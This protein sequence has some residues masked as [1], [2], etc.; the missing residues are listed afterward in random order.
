MAVGK[1]ERSGATRFV[2]RMVRI[3]FIQGG[4][5]HDF[6]DA[7]DDKLVGSL[8]RELGEGFDVCYPR[9][10]DEDDPK[11]GKW[12]P[13][14][15]REVAK[16]D[17]GASTALDH[18]PDGPRPVLVGHSIGGT[19][20]IHALAEEPPKRQPAA[21]VL[22]SAPFVGEGG[23]PS[24]EIESTTDLGGKLPD[25]VP[26][27]LFIGSEDKTAPPSHAGLYAK[28]IP[29]AQIHR[30]PGRDHQLNNELKEVAETIR[31]TVPVAAAAS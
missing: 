25:G 31:A 15:L 8:R 4:G 16:L 24:D 6:H 18:P 29:L 14:I 3:L 2:R 21:I 22:I 10:P 13:A 12:K 19:M 23:W 30:L 17:D 20:L 11:Y 9:M 28:A 7:W 27:H 1:V 5:G 26:V